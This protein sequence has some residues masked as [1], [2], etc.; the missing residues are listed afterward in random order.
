[1][2]RASSLQHV[3]GTRLML[4]MWI[5][6]ELSRLHLAPSCCVFPYFKLENLWFSAL[7][8]F[9][10]CCPSSAGN[11]S[12]AVRGW[13]GFY[14]FLPQPVIILHLVSVCSCILRI[15]SILPEYLLC[16]TV[17]DVHFIFFF[18]LAVTHVYFL[19]DASLG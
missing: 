7:F 16:G 2:P 19:I 12:V 9:P 15:H 6:K 14:C 18:E 10:M 13:A 3:G 5:T 17:C 4:S 11:F 1:M 8:P